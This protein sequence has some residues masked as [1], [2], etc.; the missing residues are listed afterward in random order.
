MTQS[1]HFGELGD[2]SHCR[3]PPLRAGLLGAWIPRCPEEQRPSGGAKNSFLLSLLCID[4]ET[5]SPEG[6]QG[7]LLLQT[8]VVRPPAAYK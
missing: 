6:L 5:E 8:G 2:I 1:A 3:C 7:W 4:G